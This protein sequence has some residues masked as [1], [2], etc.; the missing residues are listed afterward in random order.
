MAESKKLTTL[1]EAVEAIMV[2]IDNG[3]YECQDPAGIIKADLEA[4]LF[5]ARGIKVKDGDPEYALYSPNGD[6][7]VLWCRRLVEQCE[8]FDVDHAGKYPPDLYE[9]FITFWSQPNKKGQPKWWT[10]LN[11]KG[12]RF[13]IPGRLATWAQNYRPSRSSSQQPG[14]LFQAAQGLFNAAEELKN[15]M[16]TRTI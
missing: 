6:D 3:A 1:I 2:K 5:Q 13:H 9:Q 10:T 16:R 8:E 7:G 14:K 11:S 4:A 15:E 12:G